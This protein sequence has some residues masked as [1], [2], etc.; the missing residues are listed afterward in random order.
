MKK[1]PASE[2]DIPSAVDCSATLTRQTRWN[3]LSDTFIPVPNFGALF[4]PMPVGAIWRSFTAGAFGPRTSVRKSAWPGRSLL[5]HTSG[6]HQ[7]R[8]LLNAPAEPQI[9][10]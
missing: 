3:G 8:P 1:Q 5:S 9:A 2:S 4:N 10:V 7:L 6:N